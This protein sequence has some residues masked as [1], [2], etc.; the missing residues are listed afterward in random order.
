MNF[1]LLLKIVPLRNLQKTCNYKR[2]ISL[3]MINLKVTKDFLK[4]QK[5]C[6]AIGRQ[7]FDGL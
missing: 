1:G 5:N 7:S 2:K 6:K 4:I 3:P